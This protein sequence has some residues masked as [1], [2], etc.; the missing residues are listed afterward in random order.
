MD[1]N[2]TTI[3]AEAARLSREQ[4]LPIY[5]PRDAIQRVIKVLDC[6]PA[7]AAGLLR[8]AFLRDMAKPP[9]QR[10]GLA[11]SLAAVMAARFPV[12]FADASGRITTGKR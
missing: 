3:E 10:E 2:A 11:N 6:T 4:R 12:L 7:T 5:I 8:Q 1:P 9:A